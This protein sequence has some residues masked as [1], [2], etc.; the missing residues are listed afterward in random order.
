MKNTVESL[1]ASVGERKFMPYLKDKTLPLLKKVVIKPINN[2]KVEMNW[3]N[4]NY[5]SANC[6]L[7]Q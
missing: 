4:N 3:T 6:I 2:K 1:N 7:K 5:K